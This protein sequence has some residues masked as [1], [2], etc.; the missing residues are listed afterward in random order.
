MQQK[1]GYKNIPHLSQNE[2]I[3]STKKKHTK[4]IIVMKVEGMEM[5]KT[6]KH[7]DLEP[8]LI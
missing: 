2:I 6:S 1:V 7:T 5:N 4:K 3:H 8:N